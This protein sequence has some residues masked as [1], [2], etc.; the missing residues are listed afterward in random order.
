MTTENGFIE[1]RIIEA[2]QRLLTGRVNE[3]LKNWNSSF[4]LLS[5]GMMGAGKLY[6]R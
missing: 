6:L 3:L 5:L 4:R 2:V 1:Q